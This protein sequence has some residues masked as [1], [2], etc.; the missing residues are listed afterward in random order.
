VLGVPDVGVDDVFFDLGGHSLL[1]TRLISRIRTAL[2][3]EV[4]L[5]DLFANPTVAGLD[6]LLDR[7]AVT[8]PALRPS[9]RPALLPLSAAQQRLWFITRIDGASPSYAVPLGLRLHG[10]LDT[11][12][13]R[14]AL[15]DV[16]ARHEALRTVFPEVGGVAY[17]Q[18]LDSVTPD[19][20]ELDGTEDDLDRIVRAVV[21][22]P[23]DV[24]VDPPVRA[25]VVRLSTE[26]HVLLVVLHHIASDGWSLTPLLDDLGRA[27]A[28]RLTG[29][30][31]DWTPLPV[32]YA[33]YTL[34]QH[35]LLGD[36]DNPDSLLA[37]QLGF[38]RDTLAGLPDELA[39]PV[40]RPRSPTTSYQGGLVPLRLAADL[41]AG[42]VDIAR[43]RRTTL[44]MVLQAGFVAL[45]SRLGAGTDIPIGTPVAGR[46]DE[47]LDDLVGFF[48]NTLVLRA[49]T[50]GDP[51][52]AQLLDRV[53]TA[54]LAAYDNADLPFERLVEE[55]N[56][57]RSLVR[58]PLFQVMMVLQN[59][60]AADLSL[61]GLG[62]TPLSIDGGSAAF[63]LLLGLRDGYEDGRPTG[64][65]GALSYR[66]DLFDA[67]TVEL[68][69]ERLVRLLSSAVADPDRRLSDLDILGPG[70]RQRVLVDWN[71]TARP[72][73][74]VNVLDLIDARIAAV[75]DRIAVA[76]NGIELS[77]AE[78]DARANRLAAELRDHGVGP[79]RL[80][81]LSLPRVADL[82]VAVLAVLR[83]G[84]AYLPVDP[85]YPADR[86]AY[87]F[88][89][90]DPAVVL[91]TAEFAPDTERPMLVLDNPATAA[92]IAAR[93]T[94]P[95]RCAVD[96]A[97][98]AY[99]IYTSGSTGRPKG[100]VVTHANLA[101]IAEWAMTDIGPS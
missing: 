32:Q 47:A 20:V 14:A 2:G 33:D 4:R 21:D 45:L 66:T 78:L 54:D 43:Q 40:D 65:E 37:R 79:E 11:A 63:D 46:P 51:T 34:W 24:T 92:R 68:V 10:T 3:A 17:Q 99:V 97:H 28:A 76:C 90:A 86:K 87:L 62:V 100:V 74:A 58:H 19:L 44:F 61:P 56:P 59:T 69:A 16:V 85:G 95:V 70:E 98:P 22:Q 93:P 31:P 75:P 83:A 88:A 6:G 57:S 101:D 73:T 7:G 29:R 26:D 1:A 71:D 80:V 48:I 27:Y 38:W 67:D 25:A 96:P 81:A 72:A 55:L 13:L 89:D 91:T 42:L 30:A 60:A 36:A 53:R 84:G 15:A 49:D 23:F 12:A 52:F 94:I 9:A 82:V 35:E 41:H 64:I 8:R 5:A 18:I 39:L 77:Y 50:G